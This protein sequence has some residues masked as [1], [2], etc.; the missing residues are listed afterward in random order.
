MPK[1]A[2]VEIPME[3]SLLNPK[4]NSREMMKLS[5]GH[6]HPPQPNHSSGHFPIAP[7]RV[8]PHYEGH[9][10]QQFPVCSRPIGYNESYGLN[11]E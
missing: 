6:H 3:T 9:F 8:L 2:F 1:V 11:M 10:S 5:M 4:E 7:F